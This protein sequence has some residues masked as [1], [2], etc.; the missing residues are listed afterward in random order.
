MSI[1]PG[2]PGVVW[3]DMKMLSPLTSRCPSRPRTA[4]LLRAACSLALVL[5]LASCAGVRRIVKAKPDAPSGFLGQSADLMPDAPESGPFH[6]VKRTV[7]PALIKSASRKPAITVLPVNLSWLKPVRNTMA[8]VEEEKFG[9]ERPVQEVAALMQA[10]FQESVNRFGL[11]KKGNHLLLELAL[12]EFTPTS[13]SGNVMKTAAGFFIG[14]AASLAGRWIKGTI[15]IEGQ[16]RDPETGRVVYQFADR[17]GDPITIVSVRNFQSAA[18]AEII[19]GQWA[20]QFAAAV[21][22]PGGVKIKDASVFRLNPL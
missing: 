10:K 17:E 7:S 5:S 6:V 12:T 2:I 13:P 18:W 19:I 9:K 22:A 14:P 15:A 11:P 4:P 20:E 16:L 1:R 21:R 8:K 3:H